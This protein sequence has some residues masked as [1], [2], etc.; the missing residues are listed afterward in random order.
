MSRDFTVGKHFRIFPNKEL[1][2]GSFGKVYLAQDLRTNT[3]YAAKTELKSSKKSILEIESN[4]IRYVNQKLDMTPVIKNYWYGSD[5]KTNYLIIDLLGPTLE[6]LL[7]RSGGH[8]TLKTTLMITEQM[9]NRIKYYHDRNIIH[10]DIKP[11]NFLLEV[12]SPRRDFYLIDFGLSKK[13]RSSTTKQHIPYAEDRLHIGT[14][15][16]MSVN[17]HSHKEQS[18][19]DDM[20]SIGYIIVYMLKGRL[21]WQGINERNKKMRYNR[22]HQLKDVTTNQ[23]LVDGIGCKKCI[24]REV[25]CPGKQWVLNYFNYLDTLKFA[26][27]INYNFLLDGLITCMEEHGYSYDYEW[28]WDI[29]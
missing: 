17:A 2:K 26:S 14:A 1:G 16:F 13:Y 25:D 28:D 21:P 20:Y 29:V 10:R 24:H 3:L 4:V 27:E 9:I 5:R 18:R 6:T 12:S 11:D 8:F 22:I 7:K 19:R 23:E 15:R